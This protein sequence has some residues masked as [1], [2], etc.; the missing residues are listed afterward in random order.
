MTSVTPLT[1]SW[2]LAVTPCTLIATSH[3]APEREPF[4]RCGFAVVHL[5]RVE[6][7]GLPP[8]SL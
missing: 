6:D 4:S 5:R 2:F 7:V 3:T 8:R 1:V